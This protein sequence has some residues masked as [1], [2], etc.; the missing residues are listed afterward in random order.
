[1][2]THMCRTI[3][4]LALLIAGATHASAQLP[5][6]DPDYKL[7]PAIT[8]RG[9]RVFVGT[10]TGKILI[11]TSTD[12]G[13]SVTDSLV[14]SGAGPGVEVLPSELAAVWH[15]SMPN[16]ETQPDVIVALVSYTNGATTSYG[17]MRSTDFGASWTLIK[18]PVLANA[19]YVTSNSFVAW[20]T[21][22]DMTWLPDGVHGWIFGPRG[23]VATSDGGLTWSPRYAEGR[24]G[25]GHVLAFAMR[26]ELNGAASI[27]WSPEQRIYIT[28][29]GGMTFSPRTSQ[30][31]VFR[32][33][34]I[35][36]VGNEYR[37]MVFDRSKKT[38][39]GLSTWIYRSVDLGEFW[40]AKVKGNIDVEQTPHT[41]IL[42]TDAQTGVMIIRS[43]EIWA[44]TNKGTNWVNV[45]NADSVGYRMPLGIGTGFGYASITLENRYIVQA[46]TLGTNGALYRLIQWGLRT[47]G[48]DDETP[49][50]FTSA[51]LIPTPSS[52]RIRIVLE[53]PTSSNAKLMIVDARGSVMLVEHPATGEQTV[54][55]DVSELGTG[56]YRLM[57]NDGERRVVA[58]LLIAR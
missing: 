21:L 9:S 32:V 4:V 52:D 49:T 54:S 27:G 1:M 55:V 31:G 29:D 23:I 50:I 58:P 20:T 12:N 42:W 48:V 41:E 11:G 18:D 15:L 45:Q 30:M 19:L 44:T 36:W 56:H 2:T 53:R 47:T 7:A 8:G 39:Q 37:A 28:T 3:A 35:N 46:S 14:R 38:G 22:R 43:G 51:S 33:A 5:P 10:Q 13:I 6:G 57:L 16:R 26:D 25:A 17:V 24:E 40:E 34:Q